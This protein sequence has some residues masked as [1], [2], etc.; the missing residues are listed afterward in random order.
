MNLW[1][2]EEKKYISGSNS[3]IGGKDLGSVVTAINKA[4]SGCS[5]IFP[6]GNKKLFFD[7]EYARIDTAKIGMFAS[8]HNIVNDTEVIVFVYNENEWDS[9]NKEKRH[10]KIRQKILFNNMI[11]AL[12]SEMNSLMSID[13]ISKRCAT[14]EQILNRA[15]SGTS[16]MIIVLEK[17]FMDNHTFSG[18]TPRKIWTAGKEKNANNS[19]TYIKRN[20]DNSTDLP[21]IIY[22]GKGF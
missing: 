20:K 6:D 3:K 9:P 14:I 17:E 2:K 18:K 15:V 8:N 10:H 22:M 4:L 5:Y 19:R 7:D 13:D 21:P 16:L 1:I 11:S 12:S